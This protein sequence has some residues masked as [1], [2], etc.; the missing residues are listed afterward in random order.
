M[1]RSRRR[2][3]DVEFHYLYP[4]PNCIREVKLW[5]ICAGYV[6]HMGQKCTECFDEENLRKKRQFS[7]PRRR[8]D[9]EMGLKD[10]GEQVRVFGMTATNQSNSHS[11]IK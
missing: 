8:W 1:T 9:I 3:H 10:A 5:L 11:R 6:V 4:S 7:K 2:L